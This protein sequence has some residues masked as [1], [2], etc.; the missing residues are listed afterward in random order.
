MSDPG[1]Y[2]T[3]IRSGRVSDSIRALG[4]RA[5]EAGHLAEYLDALQLAFNWLAADPETFGE[6]IRDYPRAEQT[7]YVGFAGPVIVP[8]SV[9]PA[10]RT[11]YLL[12]PF[13]FSRWAGF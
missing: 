6:P 13:D 3:V 1:P 4:D 10:S 7:A 11:V 5:R 12:I 2:Y 8:Y 9:H